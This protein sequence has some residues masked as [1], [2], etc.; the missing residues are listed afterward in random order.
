VLKYKYKKLGGVIMI[1]TKC[2]EQIPNITI[3]KR[4]AS[5]YVADYRRLDFESIKEFLIKTEKQYTSFENICNRIEEIKLDSNRNVRIIA[6]ILLR[7]YLLNQDDYISTSKESDAAVINYEKAIIDESNNFDTS[8]I[9]KDFALFKHM[10]D[11]AWA[12]NDD[13]SVDEKNL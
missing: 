9:S 8:K 10:L 6:P 4:I 13:I 2:I 3:A 5:A 7:D 1:F 12:H 11:A